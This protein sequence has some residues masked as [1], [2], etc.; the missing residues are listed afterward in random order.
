MED[1]TSATAIC[2]AIKKIRKVLKKRPFEDNILKVAAEMS[3]LSRESLRRTLS[4]LVES[5]AIYISKT[6]E[7]KDSY[8]I[9][10]VEEF[11]TE[12]EFGD[13]FFY[14][15]LNFDVDQVPEIYQATTPPSR[16]IIGYEKADFLVF[17]DL[18]SKLTDDIKYLQTKIDIINDKNEKLLAQNF[19]LRLENI[20]L[21]S[22]A[23]TPPPSSFST[24]NK[25]GIS[26]DT[27]PTQTAYGTGGK[28]RSKE[29]INSPINNYHE[30]NSKDYNKLGN[31]MKTV[32][33]NQGRKQ[34]A[35][36]KKLLSHRRRKLHLLPKDFQPK[37]KT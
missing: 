3:G 26:R 1:G 30:A 10:N 35:Y 20:K 28:S 27:T 29:N 37:K 8:Y 11:G 33:T 22:C 18:I 23:H 12:E 24:A 6:A 15:D 4:S 19:E 34:R 2:D 13:S 16:D 17:L 7:D 14:K 36:E 9:F 25:E 31:P 5:G 21:A 32:P